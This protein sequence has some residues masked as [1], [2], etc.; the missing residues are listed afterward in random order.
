MKKTILLFVFTLFVFSF[1]NAQIRIKMQKESG[2]YKV[3]CIVNG[4]RLKFVF[5]TGASNV[6]ISL[7]EANLMLENGYLNKTD[8]IG[9]GKSQ[10]A[11]GSIIANTRIILRELNVG[12]IILRNIEAIVINELKAPLLL[13]QSAI[14]KL[15]K[16]QIE[17]D[18]IVVLNHKNN[19]SDAEVDKMFND[20]S[21]YFDNNL[22]TAAAEIYQKLYDNNFLS[23]KGYKKLGDCYY[24]A[25]N[26]TQALKYYLEIKDYSFNDSIKDYSEF[27]R[28]S[29]LDKIGN[30]YYYLKEYDNAILYIQKT[31]Q[32]AKSDLQ[33]YMYYWILG[34]IYFEKKECYL[35]KE[36]N[37]L[38]VDYYLKYKGYSLKN[39]GSQPPNYELGSF[40]TLIASDFVFCG[41]STL[42]N[43]FMM[44]AAKCG[45]ETAIKYCKAFDLDY[46]SFFKR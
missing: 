38:A 7:S 23:E 44:S 40:L 12:G 19:F 8:I 14:E 27:Q 4:L 35:V 24:F 13:G 28:Y 22:Y 30:C 15:G 39:L 33:N 42:G 25:N 10:I 45:E 11:D 36:N 26:Y 32:Y 3:P 5:D 21:S 9:T 17:G 37:K 41:E 20:A 1:T 16:I 46:I 6:C 29:V 2:V 43:I 31:K 18:E 34:R